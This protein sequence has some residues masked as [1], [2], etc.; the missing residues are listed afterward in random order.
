[1]ASR[2]QAALSIESGD[3]VVLQALDAMDRQ[4]TMSSTA[5]DI[6][7]S[8]PQQVHPMTGPV[9]VADAEPGDL[10]AMR[11]DDIRARQLRLA[12]GGAVNLRLSEAV[13]VPT[14]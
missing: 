7:A 10:L 11:I 9:F 4:L 14:S 8:S 2:H 6:P 1:M 5:A 3:S 12:R 13:D